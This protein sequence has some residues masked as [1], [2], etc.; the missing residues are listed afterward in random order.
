MMIKEQ[1][2]E[3]FV[4]TQERRFEATVRPQLESFCKVFVN[5]FEKLE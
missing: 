1:L 3:N 4:E 5:D 2:H